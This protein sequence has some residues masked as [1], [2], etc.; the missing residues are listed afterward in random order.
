MSNRNAWATM[1]QVARKDPLGPVRVNQLDSN[2]RWAD[3]LQRVEHLANGEHNALE[4]PWVL[5]HVDGTTGYLFDTT[6][7][8][9]TIANPATGAFTVNVASGVLTLPA[10]SVIANVSDSA[11]ESK[12]HTITWEGVSDTS[13]KVRIRELSS[14]LGAGNTWADV[15]RNFDIA[16]HAPAQ[17]PEASLLNAF[18]PK[19]RRNFLTEAATDWNALAKNTALAWNAARLEHDAD[20]AHNLNRIAKAVWWGRPSAGPS[21]S[22]ILETGIKNLTYVGTGIVELVTDAT[23][24]S[25][26]NHV[27]V[28][29]EAQPASGSEL[30]IVNAR[31]FKATR[32]RLYTYVFAGTNWTRADRSLFCAV[33][34]QEA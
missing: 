19:V 31:C 27:A 15:N 18:T 34:G 3:D 25:A 26:N 20:G 8:G 4:I 12:P 16:I 5:G 9:G 14:A 23:W 33:F 22:T 29:C 10:A 24:A 21:F 13:I 32:I 2:T 28:F 11:I 17:S 7:G 1:G 6:F 30:V